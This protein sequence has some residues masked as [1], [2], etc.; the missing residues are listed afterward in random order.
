MI[1]GDQA[2]PFRIGDQ[3]RLERLANGPDLLADTGANGARTGNDQGTFGLTE[4]LRGL[5]EIAGPLLR[6]LGRIR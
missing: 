3:R 2:L 4:E 6:I 5:I 1:F